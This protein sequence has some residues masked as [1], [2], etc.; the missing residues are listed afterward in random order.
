MSR[1]VSE[2]DERGCVLGWCIRCR[3]PVTMIWHLASEADCCWLGR[4]TERV[5]GAMENP[6]FEAYP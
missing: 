1:V 3:R 5:V 6:T 2:N 4:C